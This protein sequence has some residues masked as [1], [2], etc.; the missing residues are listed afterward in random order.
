MHTTLHYTTLD[1]N[2][3]YSYDYNYI[4]TTLHYATPLALHY[5]TLQYATLQY[6]TLH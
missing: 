2:Y 4:Y 6:A 1:Y 3:N 5:A